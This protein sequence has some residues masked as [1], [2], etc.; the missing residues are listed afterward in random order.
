MKKMA[1]KRFR[2]VFVPRIKKEKVFQFPR[3][4]PYIKKS[5]RPS[6]TLKVKTYDIHAVAEKKSLPGSHPRELQL[7]NPDTFFHHA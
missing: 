6:H 3:Q 1:Y 5:V 7:H 2:T 4:S